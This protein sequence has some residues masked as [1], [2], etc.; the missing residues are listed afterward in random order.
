M[1]DL[2]LP[3]KDQVR[4]LNIGDIVFFKEVTRLPG[5]NQMLIN[6]KG[7]T[8]FGVMLGITPP[9]GKAPSVEVVM[10]LMGQ[11]GY[12]SFDDVLGFLG[13]EAGEKCIKMFEEKYYPKRIVTP[14]GPKAETV[15]VSHLRSV[16]PMPETP[17]ETTEPA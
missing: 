9:G 11:A 13:K 2:I 4:K 7:G 12:I 1:S 15:K 17:P 5:K 6:F 8:G 3:P 16:E 14:P 10:I